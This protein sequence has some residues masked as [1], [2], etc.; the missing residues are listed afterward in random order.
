[1][2]SILLSIFSRLWSAVV[3]PLTAF[4]WGSDRAKRKAAEDALERQRKADDATAKERKETSGLSDSDIV[5]RLRRRDG[6]WRGLR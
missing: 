6:D 1:M 5:D 3:G 2:V 4:M